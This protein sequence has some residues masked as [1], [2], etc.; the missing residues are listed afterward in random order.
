ME[1]NPKT[2]TIPTAEQ[3]TIIRWYRGEKVISVY[4]C[5]TLF[6]NK[7]DK[8]C[9]AAPENYRCIDRDRWGGVRYELS[10]KA[11]SFRKKLGGKNITPRGLI[12]FKKKNMEENT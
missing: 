12:P 7:M 10:H 4:T 6:K 11:L 8:L 3:E 9:E 2:P 5:D 1:Q